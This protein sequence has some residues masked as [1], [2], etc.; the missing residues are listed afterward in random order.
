MIKNIIIGL[1]ILGFSLFATGCSTAHMGWT[2]VTQQHK[3]DDGAMP[4]YDNMFSNVAEYG[5]AARAMMKEFKVAEDVEN[6]DVADSILAL[7]EEYNMRITGDIKMYTKDDAAPAEVKHARIFSLCSLQIAKVFLNHSRYY[8]GFMPCRIML[9]EYG[10]GDRFLI[11]MDM[12]LAIHGGFP[13]PKEMLELGL[14]VKKA[15]EEI[16][17]RAANGD[18]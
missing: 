1:T 7:A 16:P 10:N 17:A 2:A 9:I 13:L 18:F 3:L 12:T 6:E 15:M 8:G 4:A 11:T 14:S 5:D